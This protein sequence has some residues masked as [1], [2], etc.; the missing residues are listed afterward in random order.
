MATVVLCR[1][2]TLD[3]N[4][5]RYPSL[6]GY[7]THFWDSV[8]SKREV[9]VYVNKSLY[10]CIS[11]QYT[12]IYM[13][14]LLSLD[15]LDSYF[16]IWTVIHHTSQSPTARFAVNVSYRHSSLFE[17]SP[18]GEVSPSIVLGMNSHKPPM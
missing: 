12:D 10:T 5:D 18:L 9:S 16:Y 4:K 15:F 6:I 2:F 14:V 7:C 13:C 3:Q 17:G 8:P 1:K 11:V